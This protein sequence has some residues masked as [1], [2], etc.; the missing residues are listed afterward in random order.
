MVSKK[1]CIFA[2]SILNNARRYDNE[3]R[4]GETAEATT[5][6][7]VRGGQ[8]GGTEDTGEKER[9]LTMGVYIGFVLIGIPCII[10]LLYCLTPKGKHWLRVNGML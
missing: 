2:P 6:Q 10:F 3:T 8:C 1:S 5:K 7:A 4:K 9:E